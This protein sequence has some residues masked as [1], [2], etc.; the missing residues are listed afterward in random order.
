MKLIGHTQLKI[1]N[2]VV[3]EKKNAI[4]SWV[5]RA[6]REGNFSDQMSPSAILPLSQWFDGCLLFDR[7]MD[8][9]ETC[10]DI[11]LPDSAANITAMAS[12]DAYSG[13]N[14]KR[15]SKDPDGWK[16]I[17]KDGKRGIQRV[18]QWTGTQGN[19]DIGAVA[20]TR[21]ANGK[22]VFADTWNDTALQ[23]GNPRPPIFEELSASFSPASSDADI[24]SISNAINLID[25]EK[26]LG[27]IISFDPNGGAGTVTV[28]SYPMATKYTHLNE[29]IAS[30]LSKTPIDTYTY[31]T[32]WQG[33]EGTLSFTYTGNYIFVCMHFEDSRPNTLAILK[34][35]T[36][37]GTSQI[38]N[39]D[40]SPWGGMHLGLAG[41]PKD[42]IPMT[43]REENGVVVEWTAMTIDKAGTKFY[44]L[45]LLNDIAI[46][47][48]TP[49]DLGGPNASHGAQPCYILPNGDFFRHTTGNINGIYYSAGKD[50]FFC[51]TEGTTTHPYETIQGFMGAGKNGTCIEKSWGTMKI[52]QFAPT[53][54]TINNLSSLARKNAGD[55]MQ[56]TYTI[57][58]EEEKED[59][60]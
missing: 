14:L 39:K 51:V 60:Q 53:I 49:P 28:R 41:M 30:V 56:L 57:T 19:G 37:D 58:E 32:G 29:E 6:T 46:N 23:E 33:I 2:R 4:T 59:E 27:Y 20:L 5:Y 45:D 31:D 54:S 17:I 12:N 21:A 38:I 10:V 16:T 1:N 35:N 15:G 25:W 47:E 34:I 18:W 42:E 22:I 36:E 50:K 55:I 26:E 7:N 52:I 44:K 48:Y 9:I 24:V 8:S 13:A 3:F 43:Y 40:L 11:S